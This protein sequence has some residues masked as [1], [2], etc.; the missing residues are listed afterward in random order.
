MPTKLFGELLAEWW[1]RYLLRGSPRYAHECWRRLE[2]EVLPR[3]GDKPPKKITPPM[4]L[5]ILR[6]IE[7]RGTLASA[8]KVKSHISQAMRYGIACG[9]VTSDPTRD[10][11]F[12]LTPHKSRPRAALLEAAKRPKSA[13]HREKM[14]ENMRRQWEDGTR[15][16]TPVWTRK[17]DAQLIRLLLKGL[18][19]REIA[20]IM[21]KTRQSIL[22]RVRDLRKT[23]DAT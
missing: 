23:Q 6:R 10:L 7:A 20:E 16:R 11:G 22:S 14:R 19:C 2:R 3:L 8:R 17:A 12:A 5:R 21:G 4:I 1:E 9:L 15:D 13:E 18:T